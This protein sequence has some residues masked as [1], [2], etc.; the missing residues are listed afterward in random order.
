MESMKKLAEDRNVTLVEYADMI[1][2]GEIPVGEVISQID[3]VDKK[4]RSGKNREHISFL[5]DRQFR[6]NLED[7][8]RA[9]HLSISEYI[10]IVIS[11][12]VAEDAKL[13]R[14]QKEEDREYRKKKPKDKRM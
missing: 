8:A 13:Y 1:K 4:R 6:K 3:T 14:K 2:R 5:V 12:Q 10:R 9:Y 7:A 11:R